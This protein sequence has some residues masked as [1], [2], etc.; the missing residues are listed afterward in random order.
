MRLFGTFTIFRITSRFCLPDKLFD[1]PY[2]LVVYDAEDQLLGARI[3]EDGQWRFPE[4]DSIPLKFEQAILHFEDKRFY[5]H[6]G[7]DPVSIM[8]AIKQNTSNGRVVSGAS[9]ITMQ[10]MRMSRN[11]QQR[12][13]YQKSIE[14]IMALR[15]E[16][17]YTKKE[18]LKMYAAHA[19]FG[20]NIVGIEAACWRYFKKSPEKL[21]WGEA[22]LL[23]VLPNAPNIMHPGKNRSELRAKR[24]R[25]L[26]SMLEEDIFSKVDYMLAIEEP[27][28][29]RPSPLPSIAYHLV[30]QFR[31]RQQNVKTT[32]KSNY[33][34]IAY[35]IASD[36]SR[37]N[38]ENDINNLAILISDTESGDVLAYIG[39]SE[40]VDANSSVDMVRAERSSGSILKP[41]LHAAMIQEGE[42]MPESLLPDIP[43]Y[44]K[45]FSP[46]NYNKNYD[47]AVPASAALYRSLN[48]PAV[49]NLQKYGVY[50][51]WD[52]LKKLNFS[53]LHYSPDHYGLSLILGGAE[54]TL[55]DLC[56]NY[57]KMGRTLYTYNRNDGKYSLDKKTNLF[58]EKE[59][60]Q[61]KLWSEY[62]I[63]FTASSIWETFDAMTLLQRPDEEGEW[64]SFV[65]DTKVAWKTGTSY[66]HR[67]AW[68]VGVSPRY[69]IGVW[70]G[71]ADGEGRNGN[72]G[73][74]V[75]GSLMFDILNS[76][77]YDSDWFMKPLDDMVELSVCKKSG[78]IASLYCKEKITSLYPSS[79]ERSEPCSYHKNIHLDHSRKH[80]INKSCATDEQSILTS[81]FELPPSMAHYYRK[82]D[83]T[84]QDMP[85]FRKGCDQESLDKPLAF[86]YPGPRE[87]V[88]LPTDIDGEEQKII[89]KASHN[90]PNTEIFWHVDDTYQGVTTEFHSIA[91]NLDP[92][93][94]QLSIIDK[95][96]NRA[97]QFLTVLEEGKGE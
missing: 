12:N 27:I 38:A 7:V 24:N 61:E 23:A 28:P 91:L 77:P 22:A 44:Y 93:S 55:W 30:E 5:M 33:Q 4:P 66:G 73:V 19:P 67:D 16:L 78:H 57:A 59:E 64:Q 15:M 29:E 17:R 58:L 60:K 36:H 45:G 52:R 87:T 80:Q 25:L 56:G 14:S 53:S 6:P 2:S 84:Y 85:P 41:F 43:L 65:S 86:I 32:I 26:K 10:L 34:Q 69:T 3:A 97:D 20:G 71:N 75:A 96:G 37:R 63:N 94:H 11:G 18:I 46:R 95:N 88:Y 74:K 31:G 50:K 8:R 40:V 13:V 49:Y 51:F 90:E 35:R 81:W 47:G 70:V 39:N 79:C 68:S 76:L 92:G 72:I 48:V 42:M 62:P 54:V 82:V 83:P 21:S 89:I 9:T 1:D